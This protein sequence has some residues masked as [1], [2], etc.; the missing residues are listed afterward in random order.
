M[1]NLQGLAFLAILWGLFTAVFWMI[2]G[3][4]AM[5]AHEKL[6]DSLEWLARQT[7]RRDQDINPSD[8]DEV[9]ESYESD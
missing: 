5:R 7:S 8:D 2:T 9:R 4:R 1:A 6:A 3:W